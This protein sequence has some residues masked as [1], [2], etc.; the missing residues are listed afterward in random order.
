MPSNI[1]YLLHLLYLFSS[2]DFFF[3]LTISSFLDVCSDAFEYVCLSFD[4]QCPVKYGEGRGV[5]LDNTCLKLFSW[6]Q[7][8][9]IPR[10][11]V[12]GSLSSLFPALCFLGGIPAVERNAKKFNLVLAV[13]QNPL[14]FFWLL[15]LCRPSI[16]LHSI[17]LWSPR[18]TLVASSEQA[19]VALWSAVSN[20]SSDSFKSLLVVC[21]SWLGLKC[22]CI[23]FFLFLFFSFLLIWIILFVCFFLSFLS[24]WLP[25][26][27]YS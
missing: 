6:V 1:Y 3:P 26:F 2:V 23:F 20:T 24:A 5:E 19:V 17:L 11:F 12:L 7:D 21:V 18:P 27:T 14:S 16:I 9:P 13:I 10:P 4:Q 8:V 22:S 15:S 25:L